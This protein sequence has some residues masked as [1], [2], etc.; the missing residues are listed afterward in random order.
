MHEQQKSGGNQICLVF[1]SNMA[2]TWEKHI[3]GLY[4]KLI[5]NAC[6]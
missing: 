1:H 6:I 3:V 2:D 5:I 4:I